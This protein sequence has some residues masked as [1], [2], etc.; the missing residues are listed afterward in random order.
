MS[1]AQPVS[2]YDTSADLSDTLVSL[3]NDGVRVAMV[4]KKHGG[5]STAWLVCRAHGL[6]SIPCLNCSQD[7]VLDCEFIVDTKEIVIFDV[8]CVDGRRCEMPYIQRLERLSTLLLPSFSG[9]SV[10]RK[11]FYP[12]SVISSEWYNSLDKSYTDG[13]I[14]HDKDAYLAKSC[15]MYKW[16]QVHTV[17]LEY[18]MRGNFVDTS[19]SVSLPCVAGHGKRLNK[20]HIW[21]CSIEGDMMARPLRYRKDKSHP[22]TCNTCKDIFRA[23]KAAI[24]IDDLRQMAQ[25]VKKRKHDST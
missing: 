13:L 2:L 20:G 22:N 24:T 10:R 21:E 4:L 14:I 17:D 18:T 9:F 8:L 11:E 7:A 5:L 16:K 25:S 1:K 3:K 19:R 6:Y 15:S 23:H 12:S